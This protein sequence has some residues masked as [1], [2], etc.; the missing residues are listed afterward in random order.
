MKLKQKVK[1]FFQHLYKNIN[2]PEMGVLPGH[3]AFYFMMMLIP[4]LTLL[5]SLLS[6][7]ELVSASITDVIYEN[8]PNNIADIVISI[9]RQE[10]SDI[11]IWVLLIP[12]LILASNCTYSM[13]ITSNSIYKVKNSNYFL[14]RIKAFM[15]LVILIA[16]FIFLLLVPTF[17][18]I[19]FK[20]IGTIITNANIVDNIYYIMFNLLKYPITF[21]FVFIAIKFLYIIAP[22]KK[23]GRKVVNYGAWFT[24][25]MW[26]IVTIGYSY[27]IEYFSSY[28]NF[29]GGISSLLF[30]ML[31]IYLISYIFV[32][33]MALNASKYE[34][35]K[36]I[37]TVEKKEHEKE[38]K[39]NENVQN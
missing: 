8:L 23:M 19:I 26:V 33:G 11:S 17:G 21:L 20:I 31:W 29:Y 15:M 32:L 1:K 9:S 12:S 6:N 22:N 16:I 36:E 18:N 25:I 7:I 30:L 35:Q 28:E 39:E 38:E 24:S 27:Y 37:E 4:L 2:R 14:N 10:P 3:L 34:V 13:I 5:G